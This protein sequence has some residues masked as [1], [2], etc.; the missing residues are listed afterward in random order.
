MTDA[1][2]AKG[3]QQ[4]V[5]SEWCC[6][7]YEHGLDLSISVRPGEETNEDF[8]SRGDRTRMSPD[9]KPAVC[10]RCEAAARDLLECRAYAGDS[11]GICGRWE[12]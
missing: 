1:T 6:S 12:E 8:C 7:Q 2:D 10:G 9:G 5:W 4:C 3:T 11:P